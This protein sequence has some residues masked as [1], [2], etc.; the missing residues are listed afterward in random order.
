MEAL[1]TTSAPP[2][3]VGPSQRVWYE[4]L[5]TAVAPFDDPA[6]TFVSKRVGNLQ[7]DPVDLALLVDQL[8]VADR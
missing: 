2:L 5:N 8:W 6:V 4:L 3:D 7:H 1:E